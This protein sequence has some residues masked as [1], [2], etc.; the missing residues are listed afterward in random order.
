MTKRVAES[1]ITKDDVEQSSSHE[2]PETSEMRSR[3]SAD[4]LASR[5]I[6]SVRRSGPSNPESSVSTSVPA[7]SLAPESKSLFSGLSLGGDAVVKAAEVPSPEKPKSLFSGLSGLVSSTDSKPTEDSD[8]G[9]FSSLFAPLDT[10]TESG[11]FGSFSFSAP[12][13]EG[14]SFPS[15][16]APKG[17]TPE[18]EGQES[19]EAEEEEEQPTSIQTVVDHGENE[20]QVY[21]SD[22]KLYKL[23]KIEK[24]DDSSKSITMKWVEKGIGFVR[25]IKSTKEDIP[26]F[27]VVVR[28]KGVFRLML[29]TALIPSVCKAETVGNKSVKFTAV[30]EEDNHLA[31]FRLNLLTE[32][33]QAAFVA[34]LPN[35]LLLAPVSEK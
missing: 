31:D 34:I 19:S 25:I 3:A 26:S 24:A 15:F 6:V 22:C 18:E 2:G 32:D 29:N 20:E 8:K 9:L 28:M 35:D 27:R 33:N 16:G 12:T 10:K 17:E 23:Q 21:Q 5:K 7:E 4:I 30:D 1:Q 13:G 11:G 14:I